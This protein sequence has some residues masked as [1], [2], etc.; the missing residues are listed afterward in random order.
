V[1]ATLLGPD[2]P[3]LFFPEG[4]ETRWWSVGDVERRIAGVGLALG[5][6][7]LPPGATVAHAASHRPEALVA[8]LGVRRAGFVP[9]PRAPE[10]DARLLLP[11]EEVVVAGPVAHLP[12]LADCPTENPDR[13]FAVPI[14]DVVYPDGSREPA[15][16]STARVAALADAFRGPRR[17]I[18]LGVADPGNPDRRAFLDAAL[19][20]GAALLLEFDAE[21]LAGSALW[22]RPTVIAVLAGEERVLS[23]ALARADRR[24]RKRLFARL[25]TLVLL[26]DARLGVDAL[27]EWSDAGVRVFRPG[28]V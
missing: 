26:G 24:A 20:G 27:A 25:D 9:A 2:D 12:E 14:T 7:G 22:A 8:D 13:S 15:T 18:A 5:D 21:F 17:P 10:A 19:V 4:W 3:L 6:L 11:E 1:T 23:N 28:S 16:R